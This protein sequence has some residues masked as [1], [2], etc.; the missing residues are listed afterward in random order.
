MEGGRCFVVNINYC[1]KKE[2]AAVL[3]QILCGQALLSANTASKRQNG[4]PEAVTADEGTKDTLCIVY[5]NFLAQQRARAFFRQQQKAQED[6]K[7]WR[8]EEDGEEKRPS[9]VGESTSYVPPFTAPSTTNAQIRDSDLS[10]RTTEADVHELFSCFGR[11]SRIVLPKDIEKQT[12]TC[13]EPENAEAAMR[14]LHCYGY[15]NMIL[16]LA[17]ARPQE[18]DTQHSLNI[19]PGM[20]W[21]CRKLPGNRPIV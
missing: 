1:F 6:G 2:R 11:I 3:S 7:I 16:H 15:D 13:Y 17:R 21:H 14:R 8:Q 5:G 12:S 4:R 20:A 19:D 10:A 18:K 9:G